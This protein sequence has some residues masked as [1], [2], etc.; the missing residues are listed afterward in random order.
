MALYFV[1]GRRGVFIWRED[2][3]NE[4]EA[5]AAGV[6]L[7]QIY[8]ERVQLCTVLD[9]ENNEGAKTRRWDLRVPAP[10]S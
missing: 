5:R 6:A 1:R 4:A 9:G 3:A 2:Y 8:G 10:I 7:E